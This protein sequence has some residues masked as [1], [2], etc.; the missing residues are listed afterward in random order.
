MATC[1]ARIVE[2]FKRRK[3]SSTWPIIGYT[4]QPNPNADGL[5]VCGGDLKVKYNSGGG[6]SCCATGP[7]ATLVCSRCNA[8]YHPNF[9]T[10]IDVEV[11]ERLLLESL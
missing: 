4:G 9:P 8:G 11:I 3:A 7:T 2:T 10:Y 6:C 5:D 1:Q